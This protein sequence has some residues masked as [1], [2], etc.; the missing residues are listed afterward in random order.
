[1]QISVRYYKSNYILLHSDIDIPR[2]IENI[3]LK[4][5]TGDIV[6]FEN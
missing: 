6:I 2:L 1:M 5:L 4:M 3:I